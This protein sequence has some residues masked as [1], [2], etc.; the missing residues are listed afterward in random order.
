MGGGG[1]SSIA[2]VR[3]AARSLCSSLFSTLIKKELL[4]YCVA[5]KT[6]ERG[7]EMRRARK[8]STATR[9]GANGPLTGKASFDVSGRRGKKGKTSAELEERRKEDDKTSKLAVP[10]RR[11]C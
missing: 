4:D 3:P 11:G 5:L 7:G 2:L 1:G 9:S 6:G 10:R 8:L